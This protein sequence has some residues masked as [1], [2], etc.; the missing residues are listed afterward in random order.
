MKEWIQKYLSESEILQLQAEIANV[1]DKTTG[2]IRL[3]LRERRKY[4]EKLYKLHELAI[5]DFEK[6]GMT[7][8]KERTGI[9]IFIVF[10]E[11]YFDI[12]ADEG[13]YSK[14]SDEVWNELEEKLKSEFRKENYFAGIINILRNMSEILQNEFPIEGNDVNQISDIIKIT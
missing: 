7:N 12:L 3:S 6:M 4:F 9:L 2:E 14:I 5:Q 10:D 11:H 13:I 8:T 1:E